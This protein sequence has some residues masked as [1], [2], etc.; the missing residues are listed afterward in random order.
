M[1]Y[2]RFLTTDIMC[3][4]LTI[5][6]TSNVNTNSD[7]LGTYYIIYVSA[8]S[9]SNVLVLGHLRLSNRGHGGNRLLRGEI[10]KPSLNANLY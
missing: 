6:K 9:M 4:L 8:Q 1:F 3:I 2:S 5:H 10:E 7:I